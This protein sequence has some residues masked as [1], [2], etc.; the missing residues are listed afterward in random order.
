ME[1]AEAIIF[2][3]RKAVG[4]YIAKAVTEL[5]N[6]ENIRLVARGQFIVKAVSVAVRLVKAGDYAYHVTIDE[7]KLSTGT[8]RKLVPKVE[9]EIAKKGPER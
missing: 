3:G 6:S 1:G 4:F 9:I 7:E 2:I 8:G 5:S